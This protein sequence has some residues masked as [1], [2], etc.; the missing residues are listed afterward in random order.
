[1]GID[2]IFYLIY[3]SVSELLF[4]YKTMVIKGSYT[5]ISDQVLCHS[6]WVSLV[7]MNF[8]YKSDVLAK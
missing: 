2:E 7:S 8:N 3:L 4:R 6:Y 1:M 5:N